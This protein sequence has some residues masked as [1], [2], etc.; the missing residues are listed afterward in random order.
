MAGP[1]GTVELAPVV[2]V[3]VVD[4][5]ALTAVVGAAVTLG[6]AAEPDVHPART[7][8]SATPAGRLDQDRS[9]RST[10]PR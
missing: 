7:A 9:A 5:E 2:V 1:V 6:I 10:P 3:L 4:G 8:A